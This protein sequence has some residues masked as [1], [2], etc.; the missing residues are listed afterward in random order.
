MQESVAVTD[1]QRSV[2]H[3]LPFFFG[4][5]DHTGLSRSLAKSTAPREKFEAEDQQNT[6][7]K[8]LARFL[9][10]LASQEVIC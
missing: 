4:S 9:H 1:V 3:D 5:F 2:P 7:R 10:S 8:Q 6:S